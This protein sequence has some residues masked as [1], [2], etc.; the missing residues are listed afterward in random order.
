MK[1]IK[2]NLGNI[3]IIAIFLIVSILILLQ[4][5]LRPMSGNYAESDSAVFIYGSQL[6]RERKSAI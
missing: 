5:P 1:F 2:K 3:A 4:S 6:I